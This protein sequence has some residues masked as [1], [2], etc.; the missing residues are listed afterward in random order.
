MA[1]P[2]VGRVPSRDL[3]PEERPDLVWNSP[4]VVRVPTETW[5]GHANRSPGFQDAKQHRQEMNVSPEVLEGVDADDGVELLIREWKAPHIGIHRRDGIL[6]L[7]L[8]EPPLPLPYPPTGRTRS[9]SPRT[10]EQGTPTSRRARTQIENPHPRPQPERWK[11]LF[12]LPE[13]MRPHIEAEKPPRVISRGRGKTIGPDQ[14]IDCSHHR[15]V[16]DERSLKGHSPT[17]AHARF[18][19]GRPGRLEAIRL[20]DQTPPVS[21][22][23]L[24]RVILPVTDIEAAASFYARL[25]G[26]PGSRVSGGRHYFDC[27]GTI[28][29]CYDPLADGDLEKVGPKPAE[30]LLQCGRPR[31][32]IQARARSGL[33]RA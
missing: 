10:R 15:T 2:P 4:F 1:T 33:S 14:G 17:L 13:G 12:E 5:R 6:D 20:A 16:R 23:H 8:E 21:E 11:D 30:R 19:P 25:L 27:R 7:P 31:C 18:G 26:I 9:R 24:F 32:R 29:A 3:V 22:P 28:L